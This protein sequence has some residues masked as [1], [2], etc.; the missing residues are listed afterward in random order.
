MDSS[1]TFLLRQLAQAFDTRAWHG[2]NLLGSLRDVTPELANWRPQPDRHNIAELTVHASYWKY[3]VCRVISDATPRSF[4]LH[5]S[6]FFPRETVQSREE[7][8]AEIALLKSWHQRLIEAVETMDPERL[9]K[10]A[11]RDGF[12]QVDLV[13]GAAAHDIYHAGQIQLIKRLHEGAADIQ[14]TPRS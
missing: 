5:G 2:T 7:W 10:P 1:I 8:R 12:A 3:R 11:N 14:S 4:D 9:T 13:F 6:N